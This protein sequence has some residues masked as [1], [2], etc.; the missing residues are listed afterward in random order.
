VIKSKTR[1]G[2][3]SVPTVVIIGGVAVTGVVTMLALTSQGLIP[4]VFNIFK[5]GGAVRTVKTAADVQF[6]VQPDQVRP[7]SFTTLVGRFVD[8]QNRAVAVEEAWYYVFED[9][10]I[11]A[12]ELKLSGSMGKNISTFKQNIPTTAFRS[13]TF[14]VRVIDRPLTPAEIGPLSSGP[15]VFGSAIQ[16][17]GPTQG[18]A[19][20]SG[21]VTMS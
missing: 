6:D 14:T 15:N 2:G 13:G 21:G 20:G 18:I 10:G 12:R 7:N 5:G 9:I 3:H 11:N 4:D 19:P 8:E 1:I 17:M 16:A